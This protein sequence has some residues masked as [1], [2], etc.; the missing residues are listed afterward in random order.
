M[1]LTK[2]FILGLVIVGISCAPTTEKAGGDDRILHGTRAAPQQ[3]P[4]QVSVQRTI[5][6]EQDGQMV[7]GVSKF[8]GGVILDKSWILTAAHCFEKD[9]TTDNLYVNSGTPDAFSYAPPSQMVKVKEV[10]LHES[11]AMSPLIVEDIALLK[12]ESPLKWSASVQKINLPSASFVPSGSGQIIGFG[13]INNDESVSSRYL[14]EATVPVSKNSDCAT[15]FKQVITDK[16]ICLGY[17]SKENACAGDSGGPFLL[18]ENGRPVVAGI[19]SFG[20]QGCYE[21]E[22]IVYTNVAKYLDWIK[23]TMKSA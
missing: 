14:L 12:L 1:I 13:A 20:N 11:F 9:Q 3:F 7:N 23:N 6:I 2:V 5:E 16:Q 15:F 4:Y 21:Y 17:G 10:H 19:T 8:C 18:K 22:P